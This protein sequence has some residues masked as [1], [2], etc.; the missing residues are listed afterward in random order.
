MLANQAKDGHA[1]GNKLQ[2][3]KSYKVARIA[4]LINGKLSKGRH[5]QNPY[6]VHTSD[7]WISDWVEKT[8]KTQRHEQDDVG[9]VLPRSRRYAALATKP[10]QALG[11]LKGP[12]HVVILTS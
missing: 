9:C 12:L 1:T 8:T 7:S 3:I 4:R 11:R 5:E 2:S 10:M 6:E